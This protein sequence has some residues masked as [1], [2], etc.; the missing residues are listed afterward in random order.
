MSLSTPSRLVTLKI[1][2]ELSGD[3]GTFSEVSVDSGLKLFA[4]ELPWRDNLPNKSRIQGGSFT[5]R[6]LNS[7][8]H[9]PCYYVLDVPGRMDIEIHKGNFCGDIA[10]GFKSD[11][12]GCIILGESIGDFDI[13][14]VRQRGVASSTNALRRFEADLAGA[15]F[16][17]K[18]LRV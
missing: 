2:P 13:K 3:Q 12:Q 7:P 10:K 5:C 1:I 16:T 18:V 15:D 8:K 14:N 6:R 4:G 9:G 17:L 11:V